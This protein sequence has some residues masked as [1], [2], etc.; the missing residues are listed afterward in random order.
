MSL[1]ESRFS[2]VTS[3]R[4]HSTRVVVV[5]EQARRLEQLAKRWGVGP[6]EALRRALDQ[7]FVGRGAMV[8]LEAGFVFLEHVTRKPEEKKSDQTEEKS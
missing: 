6:E 8:A 3:G 4:K 7:A 2:R 5:G 1:S